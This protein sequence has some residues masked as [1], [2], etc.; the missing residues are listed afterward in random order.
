MVE[1]ALMYPRYCTKRLQL[2]LCSFVF[3]YYIRV[4]LEL[5]LYVSILYRANDLAQRL[6]EKLF[7][8]LGELFEMID[9]SFLFF[10]LPQLK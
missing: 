9:V 2:K 10:Y 1:T 8:Y 5:R 4:Q 7:T 6:E 3:V